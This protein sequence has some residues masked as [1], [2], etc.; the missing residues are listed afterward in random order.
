[1]FILPFLVPDHVL[2][3]DLTSSLSGFLSIQEHRSGPWRWVAC[4]REETGLFHGF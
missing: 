1:M 4:E 2:V 3:P